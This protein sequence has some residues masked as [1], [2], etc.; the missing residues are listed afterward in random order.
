MARV[1]TGV[2]E[3]GVV[4]PFAGVISVT[5]STVKRSLCFVC[6]LLFLHHSF[7]HFQ[8]VHL[9]TKKVLTLCSFVWIGY[10]H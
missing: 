7:L 1:Q 10:E 2:T 6:V 9:S 8:L 4:G 5:E 3:L